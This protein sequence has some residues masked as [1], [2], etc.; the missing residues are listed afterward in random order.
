MRTTAPIFSPNTQQ[1]FFQRDKDGKMA[2]YV[3]T[4]DRLTE[5]K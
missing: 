2:I 1:V 4:V 5:E 3:M